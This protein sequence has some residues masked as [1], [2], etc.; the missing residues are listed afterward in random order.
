[1]SSASSNR[2]AGACA[3]FYWTGIVLTLACLVFVVAGNTELLYRFEHTAF[4]LSWALAGAAV[5]AFL[6]TEFLDS[7][8]AGEEETSAQLAP[9]WESVGA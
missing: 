4:P 6:A 8:E 5:L 9:E 7:P 2:N 3:A 1:M